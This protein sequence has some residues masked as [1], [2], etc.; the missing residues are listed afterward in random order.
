M[1]TFTDPRPGAIRV[2]S[3][4]SRVRTLL[5]LVTLLC[6]HY[7]RTGA[8]PHPSRDRIPE[9]TAR[10]RCLLWAVGLS[11]V[12]SLPQC[13]LGSLCSPGPAPEPEGGLPPAR[14]LEG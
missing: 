6:A 9:H 10:H 3:A 5:L 11:P 2:R 13:A 14:V 7:V 4:P 8:I 1:V 12:A